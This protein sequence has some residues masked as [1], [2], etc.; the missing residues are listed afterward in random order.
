MLGDSLGMGVGASSFEKSV[1]GRVADYLAKN[2]YV[3]LNNLSANGS[4]VQDL[5]NIK[6]P[7]NKIDLTI[8]LIS[9][10]DVIR[11][12]GFK[13]FEEDVKKVLEKCSKLSK[14]IIIIGPANVSQARLLPL[15]LRII[16]FYRVPKYAF[17]LEKVSSDFKKV[18]YINSANPPK[19]LGKY[20]D[21][22]YSTDKLH[23]NDQGHKFWF[24]MIKEKL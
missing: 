7:K 12:T 18:S 14:K 4:K 20:L 2:N 3:V 17:L 9:S 15:P 19:K 8:I 16:Y 23:P 5:L 13:S 21:E 24:E 6:S 10:N 1:V 22:Y 11:F